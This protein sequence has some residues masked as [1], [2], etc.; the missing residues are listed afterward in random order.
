MGALALARDGFS[1]A[2]LPTSS[3]CATSVKDGLF[4][5]R[6]P[7]AHLAL[8]SQRAQYPVARSRMRFDIETTKALPTE[9]GH[10]MPPV[11]SGAR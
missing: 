2:G 8:P 7:R 3:R 9:W 10:E 6:L 11:N 5:L 4:P 1:A